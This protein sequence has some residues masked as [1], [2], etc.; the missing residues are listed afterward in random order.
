MSSLPEPLPTRKWKKSMNGK[1]K[2]IKRWKELKQAGIHGAGASPQT[3]LS[4]RF[5]PSGCEQFQGWWGN[6]H[7]TFSWLL[8]ISPPAALGVHCGLG[9]ERAFMLVSHLIRSNQTLPGPGPCS[10]LANKQVILMH[11]APVYQEPWSRASALGTERAAASKLSQPSSIFPGYK[12]WRPFPHSLLS[13][14]CCL[15][16]CTDLFPRLPHGK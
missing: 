8:L 15:H 5:T 10:Q 6:N 9:R 13:R 2:R 14:A 11:H 7:Q 3:A 1:K 12:R 16:F 4:L